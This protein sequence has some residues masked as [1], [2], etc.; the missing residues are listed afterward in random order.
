VHW[1]INK[2]RTSSLR[3][4]GTVLCRECWRKAEDLIQAGVVAS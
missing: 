4:H 3:R 1:T 2:L